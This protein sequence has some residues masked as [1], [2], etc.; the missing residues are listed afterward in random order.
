MA[1]RLA[2]AVV[3]LVAGV[4]LLAATAAPGERGAVEARLDVEVMR[5]NPPWAPFLHLNSR[6]FVSRSTACVLD[7]PVYGFDIAAACKR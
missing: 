2:P 4:A 6:T 5:D 1:R 7:H 3:M